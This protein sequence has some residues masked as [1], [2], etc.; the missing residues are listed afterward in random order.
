MDSIAD[1]AFGNYS[2]FLSFFFK[3]LGW[4]EGLEQVVINIMEVHY[5]CR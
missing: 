5:Y 4:L 1:S 2:L 3:R